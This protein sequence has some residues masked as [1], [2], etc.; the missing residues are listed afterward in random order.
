[1]I[2]PEDSRRSAILPEP[3]RRR[4]LLVGALAAGVV[5]GARFARASRPARI[6]VLGDSIA[7]EY[8][9]ATGTGWVSLLADRTGER[10]KFTNASI[11]G[12]TTAGG[13]T[14]LPALLAEHQP[15]IVI[16]E[17]G[18]NDALRGL[19]LDASEAN[20]DAMVSAARAAGA[21]VLVL[22]MRVPPNYG[23]RY[24]EQFA[25]MFEAVAS[26]HQ[27]RLV[28]FLLAQ[29]AEQ[30]DYFQADRI[31]PNEAAQSRLAQTVWPALEELLEANEKKAQ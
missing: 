14:R 27:A 31:H 1:M 26:R 5:A 19:R 11:S 23:R 8:G 25:A 10:A 21:D 18:G 29:I 4:L 6:L 28:P 3:S 22:G 13:L 15:D 17:L 24:T 20:L 30:A 16:L 9:L 7:A 2:N 12:E